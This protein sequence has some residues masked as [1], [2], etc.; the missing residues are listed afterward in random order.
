MRMC[1]YE[2]RTDSYELNISNYYYT[3]MSCSCNLPLNC[4]ECC[5]FMYPFSWAHRDFQ[6]TYFNVLQM[7]VNIDELILEL[8]RAYKLR[9]C[10]GKYPVRV[11]LCECNY[12]FIVSVG[13]HL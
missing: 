13:I 2:F 6:N 8:M 5:I 11:R 3:I 4:S 7:T 12:L 1:Q 9:V 10:E